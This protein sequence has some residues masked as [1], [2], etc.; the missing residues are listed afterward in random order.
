MSLTSR[1]KDNLKGAIKQGNSLEVSVL[2]MSSAA[3]HNAKIAKGGELDEEEEIEVLSKEAKKRRESIEAF[4]KGG[5]EELADKERKELEILKQYLP[6]RLSEEE[7][8]ELVRETI[9]KVGAGSKADMGRVMGVVMGKVK[10][11]ADGSKV[12]DVVLRVLEG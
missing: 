9:D 4:D 7:L 10:G 6:E 5:R 8:E 2:R 3:L 1:I 11:R 12:K